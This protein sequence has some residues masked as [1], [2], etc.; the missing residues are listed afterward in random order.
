[1]MKGLY[2]IYINKSILYYLLNK[3]I[4]HRASM[5]GKYLQAVIYVSVVIL[6]YQGIAN[7]N[8]GIISQFTHQKGNNWAGP[9]STALL[10]MGSGVGSLYVKYIGKYLFKFCFFLGSFGYTAFIS[11]G[12]LFMSLG[13]TISTEISILVIS[14]VAGLICSVFYN[15]QFNYINILSKIDNR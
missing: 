3:S 15:T 2:N 11:L 9:L 5:A 12:L 6:I 4:L 10:F 7:T 14:F 8:L 1:M 13:F